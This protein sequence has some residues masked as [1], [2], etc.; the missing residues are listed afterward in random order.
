MKALAQVVGI[1]DRNRDRGHSLLATACSAGRRSGERAVCLA[2]SFWPAGTD[3]DLFV[4]TVVVTGAVRLA[5]P[6]PAMLE[7]ARYLRRAAGQRRIRLPGAGDLPPLGGCGRARSPWRCPPAGSSGCRYTDHD[8]L[9]RSPRRRWHRQWLRLGPRV[10]SWSVRW[11]RTRAIQRRETYD[12]AADRHRRRAGS[13]DEPMAGFEATAPAPTVVGGYSGQLVELTSTRTVTDCPNG[14]VWTIPT[15]RE[16][17]RVSDGRGAR[18]RRAP[19]HVSGS[20]TSTAR[21]LVIR[22]TDFR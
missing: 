12:R 5:R 2:E 19:G 17:R 20:S 13:G 6:S 18:A 16:R 9:R 4:V 22:T 10:Q 8:A 1:A 7:H 15:G 14:S 3:R 11:R 21:I